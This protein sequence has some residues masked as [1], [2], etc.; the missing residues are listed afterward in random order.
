MQLRLAL[1]ISVFILCSHVF[2]QDEIDD[3]MAPDAQVQEDVPEESPE[4][5]EKELET[6]Q[7]DQLKEPTEQKAEE[8]PPPEEPTNV[9]EAPPQVPEPKEAGGT[10][11]GAILKGTVDE[12][13]KNTRQVCDC[14]MDS[15][16]P[17]KERRGTIGTI[18][19]LGVSTY[20]PTNY[21]PDFTRLQTFTEYYTAP[22]TPMPE[23]KF[24]LKL[25]M[26][27]GSVGAELGGGFFSAKRD[28]AGSSATLS[29]TPIFW[30]LF[31]NLDTLFAEPYVVPYGF[32]GGYSALYKE[33]S[34]TLEVGEKL[35]ASS[36]QTLP[37]FGPY[38]GAGLLFS[39]NWLDEETAYDG[40]MSTGL[41][42][43]YL[44]AEVRQFG[45]TL[46][47]ED[48]NNAALGKSKGNF[49][50]DFHVDAGLKIE[51]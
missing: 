7:M 25:N 34:G 33:T 48:D 14:R 42:Q 51:F 26:T 8:T 30:G 18:F 44:Y 5:I 12:T 22:Q 50:S 43:T 20:Q 17:Y 24:G 45:A 9:V 49:G 15:S 4:A 2:A 39:L 16:V 36:G 40:Y 6:Q 3:I 1:M 37:R 28:V 47:N 13:L 41:E 38:Y 10:T 35:D 21:N 31:L 11:V 23:F 27:F 29:F 46:N 19:S 32:L